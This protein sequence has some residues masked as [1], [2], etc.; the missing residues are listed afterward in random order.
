MKF[1][2]RWPMNIAALVSLAIVQAILYHVPIDPMVTPRW[3]ASLIQQTTNINILLVGVVLGY[4]V[5]RGLLK[6]VK[7]AASPEQYERDRW[8]GIAL[9]ALAYCWLF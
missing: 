3:M 2:D 8:L 7:A 4:W 9:F 5:S 6:N 1:L